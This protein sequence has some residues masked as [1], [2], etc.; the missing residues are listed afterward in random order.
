MVTKITIAGGI[1]GGSSWLSDAA[2]VSNIY[3]YGRKLSSNTYVG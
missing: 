2:V 1:A 3:N